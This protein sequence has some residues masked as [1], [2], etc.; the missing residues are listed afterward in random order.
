[1][2][3]LISKRELLERYGVSYGALYRWK[4]MGLIPEDW[5][6]RR[7]TPTG[8]GDVFSP[9][10]DLPAR[11]ADPAARRELARGAGRKAPGAGAACAGKLAHR[12][13][14]L[15]Q[16]PLPAGGTEKHYIDRG[17]AG[18]GA[19]AKAEGSSSEMK[20][21]LNCS[22][23]TRVDGGEYGEVRVSASLRVDG[24]LRCDTRSAPAPQRSRARF[25]APVRSAAAAR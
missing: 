2:E 7:A 17:R 9:G 1:M 18:A 23:S 3:D 12:D 10:A 16:P 25:P 21:N 22:G 11:G 6:L 19:L 4:R 14:P 15:Y 24:D 5:F 8:Q 20:Q 13:G